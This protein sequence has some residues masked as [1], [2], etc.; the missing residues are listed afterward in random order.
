MNLLARRSLSVSFLIGVVL[1]LSVTVAHASPPTQPVVTSP[2]NGST[3]DTHTPLI[4][5]TGNPS[6]TDTFVVVLRNNLNVLIVRRV[7]AADDACFGTSCMLSIADTSLKN[8]KGYKLRVTARN[9]SGNVKSPLSTFD[10][11]SPGSPTLISPVDGAT[12]GRTFTVQWGEVNTATH[13]RVVL[14]NTSTGAKV[15]SGW[16]SAMSVCGSGT[17]SHTLPLVKVGNYQWRVHARQEPIPN[18]S[19]SLPRLVKVRRII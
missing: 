16:L 15:N 12:V 13:Y 4:Q 9:G 11:N 2:A 19:R 5:W 6:N 7:V 18:I 1:A 3:V 14:R 17:C 8:G 10:V